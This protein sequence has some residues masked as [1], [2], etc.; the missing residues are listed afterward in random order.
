MDIHVSIYSSP[1][2]LAGCFSKD[3]VIRCTTPTAGACVLSLI[4]HNTVDD[5]YICCCTDSHCNVKSNT[6]FPSITNETVT[7][8]T[9]IIIDNT[10]DV[11]TSPTLEPTSVM[12][13]GIIGLICVGVILLVLVVLCLILCCVC[14]KKKKRSE[15]ELAHIPNIEP[16]EA[17]H[18]DDI[19]LL[20]EIGRG[21]FAVV[22][23]A[24]RGDSELAVKVSV[25]V[26]G[27]TWP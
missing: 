27:V 8:P 9:T 3:E 16:I 26:W 5:T 25:C 14:C 18:A 1:S 11:L 2:Q 20:T 7:A 22:Y 24:T 21:R 6:V 17:S 12:A 4:Q 10:T 23:Y 15:Y 19:R 13:G